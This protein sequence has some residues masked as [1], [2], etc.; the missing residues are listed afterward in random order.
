[1]TVKKEE[2]SKKKAPT[3]PKA[4]RKPKKRGK[5]YID[6]KELMI[7]IKRSKDIDDMTPRLTEM[8]ILLTNKYG[9]SPQF[10]GYTFIEDMKG[11]AIMMLVRT[12]RAFKPEKSDNPF[13]YYTQCIKSSFIQYLNKEKKHRVIRDTL[14]IKHG[15]TP[16][17]NFQMEHEENNK[18]SDNISPDDEK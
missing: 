13:S 8:L 14:L 5:Y 15:L 3:T 12:W 6:R 16:S 2:V 10:A 1:M 11:Y 7:E 17:L 18:S 4:T 9:A